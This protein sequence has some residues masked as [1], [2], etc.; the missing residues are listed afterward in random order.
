MT[1]KVDTH[2]PIKGFIPLIDIK[3][4]KKYFQK[5]LVKLVEYLTFL[6]KSKFPQ[7]FIFKVTKNVEK[8]IIIPKN[9]KED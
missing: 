3:N 8:K 1:I 4:L 2:C 5:D 7:I 6:K 9:E